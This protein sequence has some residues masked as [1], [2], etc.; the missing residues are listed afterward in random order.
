M[1]YEKIQ[2]TQ[3]DVFTK[4]TEAA[5]EYVEILLTKSLPASL[6]SI[7]L[8][9]YMPF[10]GLP[11]YNVTQSNLR[12]GASFKKKTDRYNFSGNYI[13]IDKISALLSKNNHL[14]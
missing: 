8:R 11:Y 13:K 9:L 10:K 2:R 7:F 4:S 1:C 5:V 6:S 3:Y 12:R 14:W